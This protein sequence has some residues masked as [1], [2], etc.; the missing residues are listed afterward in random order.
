MGD[1]QRAIC[2][3]RVLR[4]WV[5]MVDATFRRRAAPNG[6]FQRSHGDAGVRGSTNRVA[7]DLA[8]PGVKDGGEIDEAAGD[9]DTGQV[10][11]P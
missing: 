5:G 4:S 2:L 6:C 1:Q 7:D 9:G 11:N 10:R 3:R 8:R